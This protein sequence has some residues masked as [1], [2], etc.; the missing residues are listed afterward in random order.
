MHTKTE[1]VTEIFEI[2]FGDNSFPESMNLE[3]NDPDR[4]MSF[5]YDEVIEKIQGFASYS[6]DEAQE[7]GN[8]MIIQKA[9]KYLENTGYVVKEIKN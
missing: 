4:R 3:S 7:Q 6:V 8:D 9:I 5:S 2:A 1:F